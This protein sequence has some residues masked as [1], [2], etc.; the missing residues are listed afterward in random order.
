MSELID[1]TSASWKEELVHQVFTPLDAESVLKIPL[2]TRQVEDFWAWGEDDKGV[3][4][5]WSVYKLL[6]K[7]KLQGE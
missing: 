7:S 3:F 6:L 4:S 1:A 5:I 2:C